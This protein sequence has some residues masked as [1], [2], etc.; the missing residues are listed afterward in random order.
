[1]FF[2]K[3]FKELE[4]RNI[5]Y[6]A[7]GG[8]A[9]NLYG[10]DRI[11]GDIDIMLSFEIENVKKFA[12]MAKD[13]GLKP[14]VP[15]E[16]IELAD[17]AKR[18]YWKTEKNMKVFSLFDPNDEFNILD[19]MIQD[20]LDFDEAYK[21]KK[22]ITDT[23]LKVSLVTIEDLIKLKEIANRTRD[24]GDIEALKKIKE[25]ENEKQ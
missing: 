19:I 13:L 2:R 16:I 25:I 21:R 23:G 17:S 3:I 12:E 4:K 20:Y 14:K 18:N 6:L 5:K 15:V 22:T 1:M 8:I 24:I 9:V 11:T 7:I 10:Y